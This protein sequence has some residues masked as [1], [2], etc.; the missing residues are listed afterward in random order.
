MES[1]YHLDLIRMQ[2]QKL[3]QT[4]PKI[5]INVCLTRP[6]MELENV[7]ARIIGAYPHIFQIQECAEGKKYTLQY[8]DILLNHIQILELSGEFSDN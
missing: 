8:T 5:H 2:V 7:S 6:K 3:F 4:H 1:K